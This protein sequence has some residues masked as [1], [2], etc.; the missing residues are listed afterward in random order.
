MPHALD[1]APA[2]PCVSSLPT[3][4]PVRILVQA[5]S[6]SWTGGPD[7]SVSLVEGVPAFI[8]TIRALQTVLPGVEVVVI[9]PEFDADG[10]LETLLQRHGCTDVGLHFSHDRSPLHRM[11]AAT[12]DLAESALILRINGMNLF[13]DPRSIR[14]LL[15]AVAMAGPLDCYKF[16]DDYPAVLTADV[17]RIGALRRAAAALPVENEFHVHIKHYLSHREGFVVHEHPR[18]LHYTPDEIAVFKRRFL[19]LQRCEHAAIDEGRTLP[20]GDQLKFHYELAAHALPPAA[21]VL[22][23]GCGSGFGAACLH[24]LGHTVL[25][26]DLDPVTIEQARARYPENTRL[27]F[28]AM[29]A[30][31]TG[32]PDDSLD[33]I[34]TFE[35]IEHVTSIPAYLR[36]LH[37]IVKPGGQVFFSTPQNCFGRHPLSCWHHVEFSAAEFRGIVA[38]TF[39]VVDFVGIKQ[40]RI[41]FPGDPIGNNSFIAARPRK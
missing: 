9:A 10:T 14:D 6:R 13:V 26:G 1:S 40:G 23:I 28:Q 12:Q 22:D 2:L 15:A 33:A 39:D 19:E 5:S 27:R 29:N 17:Y 8:H 30:E 32:L 11:L 16:A 18:M 34:T 3:T 4:T 24:A 25:A 31:C 20:T 7:C 36:E 35:T 38:T 41:H 37:R 21:R